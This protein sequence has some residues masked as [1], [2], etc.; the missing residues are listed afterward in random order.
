MIWR[1]NGDVVLQTTARSHVREALID[2]TFRQPSESRDVFLLPILSR[3][4]ANN[5]WEHIP[6]IVSTYVVDA[7]KLKGR[8]FDRFRRWLKAAC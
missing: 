5:G 4:E 7:R 1:L 3:I 2:S 6:Q 8:C